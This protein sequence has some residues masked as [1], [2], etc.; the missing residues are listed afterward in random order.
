MNP[1]GCRRG[2]TLLETLFSLV[3]VVMAS[4]ILFSV[5]S[6]NTNSNKSAAQNSKSQFILQGLLEE[7]IY[8]E[9]RTDGE[10][11]FS[12]LQQDG[13][14]LDADG[15]FI[16]DYDDKTARLSFVESD[17]IDS[18]QGVL[19]AVLEMVSN[20]EDKL[21]AKLQYLFWDEV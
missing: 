7:V 20:K 9:K 2:Y 18:Q 14:Q 13:W 15:V 6:A 16:R 10:N 5:V 19:T 11:F 17:D 8:T 4:I 21:Y 3:L 12:K 1:F